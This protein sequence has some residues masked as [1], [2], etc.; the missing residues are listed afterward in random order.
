MTTDTVEGELT[1][2]LSAMTLEEK[3]AQITAW[4]FD[5]FWSHK[6]ERTLEDRIAA[7]R[8]V[9]P[10]EIVP[11]EGLGIISTHL[12]DLTARLAAEAANALQRHVIENTRHQ[13]PVLIHDEGVHGLIGNGATC[14]PS[15][16]AMAASWDTALLEQVAH[17]IGRE[18]RTRGI[19]QILSPT[20]NLG[21][22]P[23]CGRTEETYGEDPHL[24]SRMAVAFIRGVQS[25]G[26]ICTPK[27]FV[28]NFEGDG[29][30]DSF[31][32]H[33]TERMMREVFFP[34]FEA[35]IREAG[36]LSLMSAYGSSDGIPCSANRWLLTDVLRGEWDFPGFV[37]SDYGSVIH[38]HEL[39]LTASSKQE[40]AC[41]SLAAGLD[42]ELPR[43]VCFADPLR[44]AFEKE[45]VPIGVLDGAVRRVL[46]AKKLIGAFENRFADPDEAERVSNCAEHRALARKMARRSVVLLKNDGAIL[47]LSRDIGSL[48][49]IGHN[50]DTIELG[51]YSWG[52][53]SR[54]HVITP[55]AGLRQ[56]LRHSATRIETAAGCDIASDSRD[57]FTEAVAM[58]KRC[59]AVVMFMGSSV[60]LTGEARDRI[61]LDLPGV[62]PELI[63]AIAAT[64]KPLVVVLVT[65]S[66]HTIAHWV[67]KVPAI[68]QA[69]YSGEEGGN[70]IAEILFG[71][72][73]PGGKLPITI[74]RAVGQCPVYH[75]FKPSGRGDV[76][77]KLGQAGGVQFPFGH[78][79][80]YTTFAYTDLLIDPPAPLIG[81]PVHIRCTVRNEGPREGDEVVQLYTHDLLASVA[82]P[83]RELK[84]FE[85]VSLVPGE[86]R[87]IEFLLRPGDFEF[88]DEK[89]RPVTEAGAVDI[90]LGSSCEDIRLRGTLELRDRRVKRPD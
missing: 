86:Q 59:D 23:R 17:A 20:L 11:P 33:Y 52:P 30:R 13:I 48:A 8:A 81:E 78:G 31:A 75:N 49:V 50:A 61:D 12:R 18:A 6:G 67:D 83:L 36:A 77:T 47:P 39:H 80:A 55:L 1:E 58:A 53:Y 89:L 74:P 85:R 42:I 28:A 76:Y 25:E 10:G 51:D 45:L 73:G 71:A 64:G 57:G 43:A 70:A 65:G 2:L 40:A 54:E 5:A 38:Q 56:F 37:V 15:A 9:A 46:R 66:V 87:V 62:Q 90:L 88:L 7:I 32:V 3:L 22:D 69:W 68:L 16:L 72:S 41:K 82:R 21:R 27:H 14:F 26:V 60:K 84:G 29:G 24:A 44:E 79:L 35:A 63:E 19:R 4:F 34:P